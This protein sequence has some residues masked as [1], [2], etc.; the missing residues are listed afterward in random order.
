MVYTLI[1]SIVEKLY[2]KMM[3]KKLING[4]IVMNNLKTMLKK[5]TNSKVMY[6]QKNDLND[7]FFIV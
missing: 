4:I 7:H 6:T 5:A 2:M 3:L 1:V